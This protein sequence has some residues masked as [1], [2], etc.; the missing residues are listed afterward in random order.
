L[1]LVDTPYVREAGYAQRY[2]DRRFESAH[3]PRTDQRERAA[4]RALLATVQVTGGPW[5]DAPAG[6]GRLSGELPGPVVQLDRDRTMLDAA[7]AARDRVCATATA[8]PFADKTFRGALCCRLLQHIA[9]S[10]ERRAILR[11]LARVTDGPVVLSF[12][13]AASL[14][15]LRRLVRRALGKNRS[16]R[17]AV[18]RGTLLRD[19]RAAGL[20]P[21]RF[22]AIGRFVAEQTF[23]LCHSGA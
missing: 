12:F 6:A 14:L 15:S 10:E 17:C 19:A 18:L 5:L 22:H 11:E 1:P 21:L 8:L 13:D 4:L 9:S 3:G 2:R 23:L 20:Q 7:G 16:G